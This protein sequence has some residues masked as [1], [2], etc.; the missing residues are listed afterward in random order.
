MLS[1]KGD[2]RE[3]AT[4]FFSYLIE[5]DKKDVDLIYAEKISEKGLG[6]A[7]MER[8]KKASKKHRYITL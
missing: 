5:L 7:M 1:E 8:L 3:A 6:R 2:L 4:N